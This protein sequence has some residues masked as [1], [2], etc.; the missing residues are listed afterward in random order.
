MSLRSANRWAPVA[1][2]AVFFGLCIPLLGQDV[3][4]FDDLDERLFHLPTIQQFMV[5]LPQPDLVDYPSATTPLYHLVMA[6]IGLVIG[7]EVGGLRA[8][9]LLISMLA[10]WGA[11]W[12]MGKRGALLALP[13]ALSPYFVGP[14]IRLSTDN[15]ALL[16]IFV[17]LG[18]MVR[19]E[20]RPLGAGLAAAAAVLTRQIHAWVL[21]LLLIRAIQVRGVRSWAA[22]GVPALL[23]IGV[24][25]MWGALTPPAFAKGHSSGLNP[26]TTVFAVSMFGLYG[27]F[28]IGWLGSTA[29]TH[30]RRLV[31]AAA[32]GMLLLCALSMPYTAD[33]NRWGGAIWQLAARTPDLL[34]VPLSFWVLFPLGAAVLA[35][36]ASTGKRG[37]LLALAVGMWLLVSLASS[38][39]Y[40]KY[41]DPMALFILG[42]AVDR[43]E[44]HRMAW[45]GPALLSLGLGAVTILRLYG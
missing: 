27:P 29:R 4:V 32:V 39:A 34:D 41:Y 43:L 44:G 45:V 2:L 25:G 9:N 15:A 11:I 20:E 19:D 14:A 38:R 40:Q 31:G 5:Q 28:L 1:V 6:T 36:I 22:L 8:A 3:A 23:L 24:V 18:L 42:M 37:V 17:S 35:A 7:D 33:P 21:G 13:L 16:G 10:L 26:H 30:W 12:A